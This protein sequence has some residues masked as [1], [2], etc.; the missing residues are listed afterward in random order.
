MEAGKRLTVVVTRCE[1]GKGPLTSML[2]DRGF[3]VLHWPT[4]RFEEPVD[5]L[6]LEQ[7]LI[8]L[9]NFSWIVFSSPRSVDAVVRRRPDFPPGPQVA[10]IGTSTAAALDQAGWPVH[11]MP[12][13][14]T[15]DAL[16]DA[17][18]SHRSSEVPVFFP[19]SDIARSTIN[20]GLVA[21]GFEVHQVV[22]YR[23]VEVE[24]DRQICLDDVDR[25]RPSFVTFA[26]PSAAVALHRALGVED[27]QRV[28]AGT[29]AVAVGP[30]TARA[31][32]ELGCPPVE[33]APIQTLSGLVDAVEKVAD[34]LE[35]PSRRL[36]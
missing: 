22:A 26:S 4:I 25:H 10:A 1:A 17:F 32:D 27:F 23:T 6:P 19:A 36:D 11:L 13:N 28:L 7:A 8:G 14:F 24:L 30:V 12:E 35:N 18:G 34:R 9:E 29:P 15:A 2:E 21:L 33:V 31:L 20:R 3:H 5:P 16:V